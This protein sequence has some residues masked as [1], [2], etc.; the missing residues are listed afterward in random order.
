KSL[1]QNRSLVTGAESRLDIWQQIESIL[2]PGDG[3]LDAA[4]GNLFT[5]LSALASQPGETAL[6][7]QVLHA[8]SCLARGVNRTVASLDLLTQNVIRDLKAAIAEVNR[9]TEELSTLD[10]A[11]RHELARGRQP[12][13]L[14]DRRGELLTELAGYV[15]LD[16]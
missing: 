3:S 12:N 4:A 11:I 8:A 1:V 2:Q 15:D 9:L 14:L 6:T 13:T 16:P 7:T 5:A 10:S